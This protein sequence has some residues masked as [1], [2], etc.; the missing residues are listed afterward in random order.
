LL[1]PEE[2]EGI[3]AAFAQLAARL[4]DRQTLQL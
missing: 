1:D 4:A 2:A 3:S